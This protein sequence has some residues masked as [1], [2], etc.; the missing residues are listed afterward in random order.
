M[1][2]YFAYGSNMLQDQMKERCP[3]HKYFGHGI[4]KG[5]RWIITTRG[6]ANIIKSE[7]DEIHGVVYR[8]NAEDESTLDKA[9]GVHS[10][11]YWKETL[12]V[13]VEKTCY[14]CLVYVDPIEV[15]GRPKD[16]YIGRI[17]R[18][19]SDAELNPEYVERYIRKFIPLQ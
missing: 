15:E 9:E 1:K 14:P 10:G 7:K 4:L 12:R 11:S 19:V 16:E 18:G 8:I 13:E 17:N 2:L 3:G 6:Y 5:F